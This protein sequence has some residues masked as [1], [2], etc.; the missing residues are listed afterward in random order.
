[1]EPSQPL[2]VLQPKG[3]SYKTVFFVFLCFF[4]F[5]L[6]AVGG[7]LLGRHTNTQVVMTHTSSN[8]TEKEEISVPTV[9]VIP[10]APAASEK[11]EENT[12]QQYTDTDI[13]FSLSYPKNWILKKTY[14]K[15]ISKLAPA[16]VLSGIELD[17][18]D[19]TATFVV[20]VI[21]G[22]NANTIASWWQTGSHV[23]FTTTQP[24]FS[25]KGQDAIKVSSTPG[26]N[27][28]A[29]V[30]DETYFLWKGNV[31][32]LSMQYTPYVLTPDL[33]TIY[34]SFAFPQE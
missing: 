18:P 21:D 22:K 11:L 16:S 8:A 23:A 27:P 10:S 2:E 32:F 12:P 3:K 7:Y 31:Y 19:K 4:V 28:V 29:R 14:G 20:N 34:N 9:T 17:N 25:F 5:L 30:Q 24:N 6:G 15:G 26:G 33:V 1:M 13:P